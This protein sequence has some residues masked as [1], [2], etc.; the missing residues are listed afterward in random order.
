[1]ETRSGGIYKDSFISFMKQSR[2]VCSTQ[3]TTS[4]ELKQM[5]V[6]RQIEREGKDIIWPEK[7]IM[8]LLHQYEA[9]VAAEYVGT[10]TLWDRGWE[11]FI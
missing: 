6:Q 2:V 10:A 11:G 3:V 1:M 8:K 9:P 5:I 4:S 7:D